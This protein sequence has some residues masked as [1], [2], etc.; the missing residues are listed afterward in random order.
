MYAFISVDAFYT[1]RDSKMTIAEAIAQHL[2]YR[3]PRSD[4]LVCRVDGL[5]ILCLI[6]F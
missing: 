3:E 4:V 2:V 5:A 1:V 6:P